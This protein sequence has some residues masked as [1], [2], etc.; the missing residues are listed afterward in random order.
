[1]GGAGPVVRTWRRAVGGLLL[2]VCPLAVFL[3]L[4][5]CQWLPLAALLPETT[6]GSMTLADAVAWSLPWR[7]LAGL[8]LADHG[9]FHEWMTYTGV[10]TLVLAG[11]GAWALWR[12]GER[13]WLMGGLI[14]LL[15][16]A[17]WFS[18]G[19]NGGLFQALWHV[20]PG[21][22]LLRVPPRAWVLVVFAV[23]VLAGFGMEGTG[24]KRQEA[25]SRRRVGRWLRL[26]VG[27]FP[28]MLALGY[29]VAV[30][31]P[32]LNLVMFGLVTPL[33]VALVGFSSRVGTGLK[34]GTLKPETLISLAAVLLVAVDLLI[35]DRTLVGARPPEDVFAAG[36]EAAEWLAAQPGRFRVYSPSYSVPQHVAERYGLALADGVDPLQ[37][38][39]YADYLT[40]AAGLEPQGYSVTLPPFPE[41]ADV[42]TALREVAP[43]A[44]MLGRLGVR[45]V[46]AAFPIAGCGSYAAD[47]GLELV[48]RFGGVYVY[49]NEE[50]R[51]VAD[52]GEA[53]IV[54]SDGTALFRYRPWPVY[55]GWVISGVTGAGLLVW[56]WWGRGQ[57]A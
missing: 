29:R 39:A 36:R 4:A 47:C 30:G 2:A 44:R 57:D 15:V 33:A 40:R 56:W 24:G 20:V 49:R 48:G 35:V 46:A 21:L 50:V 13:R 25:S 45:Y 7:Y 52:A 37:L 32:P 55:A 41:G 11:V 26:A 38:R 23:A 10:S 18:L 5:A 43:D 22:G 27:T 51:P 9:G 8:L 34:P 14:G 54:L 1:M 12:R 19:E 53:A 3:G 28:P 16:G 31:A 17:A 6:R 42:S